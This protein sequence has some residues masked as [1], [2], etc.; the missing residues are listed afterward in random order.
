MIPC[1]L[2]AGRVHRG[3]FNFGGSG[4]RALSIAC[5]V[6]QPTEFQVPTVPVPDWMAALSTEG[7]TE[8]TP[9]FTPEHVVLGPRR[10]DRAWYERTQ[11]HWPRATWLVHPSP[12]AAV[13]AVQDG[14]I[15]AIVA[16]TADD[17]AIAE[18]SE[19]ERR[20]A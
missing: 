4:W 16:P 14:Q 2:P 19:Q 1:L 10:I 18:M 5:I 9:A 15:V 11:T 20:A 8:Q 7:M 17:E 3:N 12:M 6:R 13:L